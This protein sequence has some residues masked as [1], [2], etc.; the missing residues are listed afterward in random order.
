MNGEKGFTYPAALVMIIIVSSSLMGAQE[1]WSTIMKR[2]TEKELLFRGHQ[3]YKAIES[4]YNSSPGSTRAYPKR[5]EHLIKDNRFPGTKR[6]LRKAFSDP[7]TKDAWG[8]I[9]DGKGGI[10]GV[11]SKSGQAPI[12]TA[13]FKEEFESFEKKKKYSDWKFLYEPKK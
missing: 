5:L 1:Y 3:I 10:K 8:I 11:F 4:Y 7:V 6:H 12:K 9:Y 13:N 2:E